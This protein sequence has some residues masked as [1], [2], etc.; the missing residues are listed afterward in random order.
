MIHEK[1]DIRPPSTSQ[2]IKSLARRGFSAKSSG[3]V[4]VSTVNTVAT[5]DARIK[6]ARRN[7]PCEPRISVLNSFLLIHQR[8]ICERARA[9]SWCAYGL[10]DCVPAQPSHVLSLGH[11][12]HARD[13]EL[14][15]CGGGRHFHDARQQ[16][17]DV[18]L[19]NVWPWRSSLT[20]T[21]RLEDDI[22]GTRGELGCS[23]R[24]WEDR[25]LRSPRLTRRAR[26]P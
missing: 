10:P 3:L 24:I 1:V 26:F 13:D 21:S 14:P 11:A 7:G 12:A 25:P 2:E 17:G 19:T 8:I 22:T 5:G 9:R 23:D 18:R 20:V 15:A 16:Y 4:G 6:K